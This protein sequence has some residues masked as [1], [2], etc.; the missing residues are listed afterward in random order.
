M[1]HTPL[2]SRRSPRARRPPYPQ[3][4][5]L[6]PAG[7][8]RALAE[9]DADGAEASPAAASRSGGREE[10]SRA[11]QLRRALSVGE[12]APLVPQ[13]ADNMARERWR[14]CVAA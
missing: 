1:Q 13:L 10:S 11:R 2:K 14:R 12:G 5:P 7:R 3:N 4:R 8:L 9:I 6:F